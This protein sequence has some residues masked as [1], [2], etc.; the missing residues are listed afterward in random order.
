M[1]TYGW[2]YEIENYFHILYKKLT[3]CCVRVNESR[4]VLFNKVVDTS[5][6]NVSDESQAERERIFVAL[7]ML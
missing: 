4:D 1:V 3:F 2:K 6:L 5:K 7:F